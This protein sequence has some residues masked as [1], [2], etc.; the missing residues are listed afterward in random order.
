MLQRFV[1]AAA[2]EAEIERV[3]SLSGAALRRRL[4]IRKT[5]PRVAGRQCRPKLRHNGFSNL[6]AT[7]NRWFA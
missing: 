2:V 1:D 7:S 5:L 4:D 3:G 6:T